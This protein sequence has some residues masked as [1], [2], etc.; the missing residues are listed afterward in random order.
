[1]QVE[2]IELGM[3]S[4][5]TSQLPVAAQTGGESLRGH[6]RAVGVSVN[7]KDINI[8]PK[9]F[10]DAPNT[11]LSGTIGELP[12]IPYTTIFHTELPFKFYK[13][14]AG[15]RF[16]DVS[17]RFRTR[18]KNDAVLLDTGRLIILLKNRDVH[19]I[20]HLYV[21]LDDNAVY[22]PVRKRSC[23]NDGQWHRVTVSVLVLCTPL[24]SLWLQCGI[25]CIDL[26]SSTLAICM[27]ERL[28]TVEP[29]LDGDD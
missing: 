14:R 18:S 22:L 24:W 29:S 1:M 15:V 27:R 8:L 20:V 11:T 21:G 28:S 19:V 7:G 4:T 26:L 25:C 2:H 12:F 17:F 9:V 5:L 10:V 13:E 6:I 16:Q 23:M 3:F